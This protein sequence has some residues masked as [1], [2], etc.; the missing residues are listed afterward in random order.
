MGNIPKVGLYMSMADTAASNKVGFE[1]LEHR[2]NTNSIV[3]ILNGTWANWSPT[4][5]Y[6][7]TTI[8][9]RSNIAKYIQVGS[10]VFFDFMQ[11]GPGNTGVSVTDMSFTLPVEPLTGTSRYIPLSGI[12]YHGATYQDPMPYVD[13]IN[14]GLTAGKR[15]CRFRNFLSITTSAYRIEVSGRYEVS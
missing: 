13:T 10:T 11:T 9:L 1:E 4:I 6:S 3:D 14:T 7:G 5:A 12:E 15:C 8:P 2:E